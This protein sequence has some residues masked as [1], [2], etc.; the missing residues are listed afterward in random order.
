LDLTS[1]NRSQEA[2]SQEPPKLRIIVASNI[3][4]YREGL[5]A[6][7]NFDGRLEVVAQTHLAEAPAAAARL[8]ADAIVLDASTADGRELARR[9]RT[10]NPDL[11]LVGFGISDSAADV[12]ACA[13]SGLVGFI[14]QEGSVDALVTAVTDASRGEISCSPK[15]TNILCS[16]LARLANGGA[17]P[18]TSLTPR[19]LE[20][21]GMIA[22][23]CSNKEIAKGLSIGPATVKNHV[24]NIL[25]KLHVRRRSAIF[26]KMWKAEPR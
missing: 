21:A 15:I 1:D 25:D 5:A 8:D 6:S 14:G 23:G 9:A 26:G 10:S 22:E 4:L 3:R 24:H 7:V 11:P 18:E 19:E 12:I 16:R 2:A 13:E 20:I 17:S